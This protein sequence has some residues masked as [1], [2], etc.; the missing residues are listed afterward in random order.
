MLV[1]LDGESDTYCVNADCPAQRVQRIAHFGSRSAM[2]IEGLG[3]QRVTQFVNAGLLQDVADIFT[4]T[5]ESLEGLEGFGKVS[6]ANLLTSIES[7]KSRGLAHVLVGLS[8]RHVGPTIAGLIAREMRDI[9]SLRSSR[10]AELAAIEGVGPVIAASMAAFFSV[11]QNAALVERL[12]MSGVRLAVE[13]GST[14]QERRLR[15]TLAGRSVVVSGT[16]DGFTREEAERA[17]VERGGKSPSSVS[18]RTFALVVGAAPG[19]SKLTKAEASGVPILDE[20]AFVR[21][22][23]SGELD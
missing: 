13:A 18:A 12:R 7:A 10:E 6:A 9:D 1:R 4:L 5:H 22:L 3:E 17:I 23:E 16:L 21:L 15:Q 14:S 11:E 19:A 2:D 8:I 20:V